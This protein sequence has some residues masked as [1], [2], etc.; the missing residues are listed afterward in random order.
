[1]PSILILGGGL[2]GLFAALK[3]S[4]RPCTILTPTPLGTGASSAW[5]QGGIAAAIGEGDSIDSHVADTLRAGAGLCDAAM[6]RRMVSEAGSAIHDLLAFGVPFDRDLAGRL[7]QSR[8]AAHSAARIVRV[9]GD[10]AGAK[11]MEALIAAVRQTPSIRIIEDAEAHAILRDGSGAI[12]GAK[13]RVKGRDLT[14]FASDL[15]VA[16]G[17]AGK[18]FAVTTNP[19]Q[20]WGAGLAMAFAAGAS[21]VNAEFVQFHPTALDIGGDPAPLATEALR[22]E[23]ATLI[24]RDGH[25]FMMEV[26]PEAELAPRD[27]VARGVFASIAAGKGAF[28]DCRSAIGAHFAEKFPNVYASCRAAGIDPAQELIPVA[29]AAHYHMGG[30]WTD[31]DGRAIGEGAPAGL[32]AIGEAA[33]TGVHGANRLASNSL[34]EAVVFAARAAATIGA[35]G[36]V[37]EV[38]IKDDGPDLMPEDGST[39][40]I[41]A[42]R[43][44]MQAKVGVLREAEG[45]HAALIQFGRFA[46]TR[47]DRRLPAMAEAAALVAR[48]ALARKES[49]GAHARADYPALSLKAEWSVQR[50]DPRRD[51]VSVQFLPCP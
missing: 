30:I 8:E 41:Q 34:L 4:P 21:I 47:R 16:T 23:G 38:E 31:A 49:R 7:V 29:P 18:L 43:A 26:H 24:D 19:S 33:A 2:A 51:D 35:K 3:L 5:A 22:G 9:R 48:A 46:D 17:G 50:K 27:V 44:M 13:A 32:Y 45:L 15:V 25:R 12:A 20:S 40:E 10:M 6:V 42:L 28:L 11:I 37:A 14:F 36:P 39:A 1:M